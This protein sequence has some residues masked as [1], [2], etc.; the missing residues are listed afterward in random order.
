MSS[1]KSKYV[2]IDDIKFNKPKPYS[3]GK[4]SAVS[5]LLNNKGFNIQ[6]P[7]LLSLYG[8]NIYKDDSD[9]I[10]S[11]NLVLQFNPTV[12]KPNRV[13]NFENKIKNLDKHVSH[14][15]NLEHK[16]WLHESKPIS[17]DYMDALQKKSLYYSLLQNME[18]NHSKPPTF[19][20][21]IQYY[22]N[23]IQ[24]L[25]IFDKDKN[26]LNY[27][28]EE[29]EKKLK[30]EIIV[31]CIINPSIYI[32]AQNFGITYNLK[33]LQIIDKKTPTKK[34]KAVKS[35]KPTNTINNY[36]NDGNKLSDSS[37]EN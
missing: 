6:T 11:I 24:N 15:A 26:K 14:K 30:G 5:L 2:N 34:T 17:E 12:D 1:I 8:V 13:K 37:D 18:I 19:K 22:N 27:S 36:F 21:K 20:V 35:I 31:K 16:S 25:I 33:A 32:V 10:K 29:L 28:I 9:N 23:E 7:R 3:K 4:G